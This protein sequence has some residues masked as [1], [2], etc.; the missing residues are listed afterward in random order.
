MFLGSTAALDP[1]NLDSIKFSDPALFKVFIFWHLFL[2]Y[3]LRST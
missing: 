1:I 2:I 3:N